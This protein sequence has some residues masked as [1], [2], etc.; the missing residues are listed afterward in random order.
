MRVTLDRWSLAC[1]GLDRPENAEDYEQFLL[2]E[3]FPAMRNI[4]GFL[5]A[6]VLRREDGEEVD[7]V[8]LTRFASIAGIRAFAGDD[9]E[10]PVIEPRAAEPLAH[11]DERAVHY[12]TASFKS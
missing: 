10:V 3:L 12:D 8:T 5:G 11:Y 4:Q 6:D 2:T 9:F 1:G 7:F